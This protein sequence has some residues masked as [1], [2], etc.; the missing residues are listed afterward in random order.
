MADVE[1]KSQNTVDI[2]GLD[3]LKADLTLHA[4]DTFKTDGT[5]TYDIKPLKSDYGFDIKPLKSDYTYDIRPLQVDDNIKVDLRPVTLDLCMTAN[6]GK[7]PDLCVR[8][9][10]RHRVAFS[11]FGMEVWGFTLSGEQEMVV[12]E[13]D[14][15]PQVAIA[16]APANWAPMP[17]HEA[18]RDAPKAEPPTRTG[19]G[20][21][22]RLGS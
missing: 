11:L 15:R 18:P 17:R 6:I 12:Q 1:V 13:L 5:N 4:P 21:R 16:G 9:P 7:V 8:Q 10:Y 14:R 3:N 22:I 19:N 20:L 2:V